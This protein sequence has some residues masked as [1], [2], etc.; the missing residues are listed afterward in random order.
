[1]LAFELDYEK[2]IGSADVDIRLFTDGF[3]LL[4]VDE[5]RGR[6]NSQEL[7]KCQLKL[8]HPTHFQK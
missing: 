6:G 5:E 2:V 8:P 7:D 1:M 4:I 3:D